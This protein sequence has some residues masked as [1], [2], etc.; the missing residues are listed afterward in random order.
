MK[1]HKVSSRN[2]LLHKTFTASAFLGITLISIAIV[3]Q[4]AG[5]A[6]K[7]AIRNEPSRGKATPDL[8]RKPIKGQDRKSLLSREPVSVEHEEQREHVVRRSRFGESIADLLIRFNL[9]LKERQLW[10]RSIQRHF[11]EKGLPAGKEVHF[12]FSRPTSGPRGQSWQDR[13]KALEIDY[14]DDW[15][16]TW[17]KGSN[18]ILFRRQEKPYDVE[19]KTVSAVVENSLFEDGRKAGINPAILS[20]LTDIFTWDVDLEKDI[21]QGD[22]LKILF[23][24]RTRKGQPAKTSLRILAA[25]LINAGRKLSAVYFEKQK[26]QGNYYNLEGRSLARAFLRFPLEFTS[27]TSHFT[28]SRFH[29]ILKANLPHYGVDFA[30]EKGTPVRAIGD[31]VIAYADWKLGGY[32]RLVEVQHD[33]NFTSRYAHLNGYARGI[34]AG[35]AV[36]KG[37]IIGYVGSSGRTTGPHLHFELYKDQQYIDPLSVDFPAEDTIEPALQR[38]F[39]N[40]IETFLVELSS[41]P[42]T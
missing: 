37:Q 39:N 19:L 24:Q 42:Q 22:S 4:N 7:K 11:P 23:E 21:R 18:G 14:S 10:T 9:P 40:T 36:K 41:G 20:Q 6:S 1:A 25:E 35:T 31:G 38:L 32:G 3:P 33:S 13:L 26:G 15:S 8:V 16:F 2:L 34:R 17:E 12:Y 29:P 30:A 28:D 5:A 27:I